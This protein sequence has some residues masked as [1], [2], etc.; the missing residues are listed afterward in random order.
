MEKIL[1]RYGNAD[2]T[3][4]E[5]SKEVGLSWHTLYKH[6]YRDKGMR[7]FTSF[8][9]KRVLL[10][11]KGKSYTVPELAKK[12]DVAESTLYKCHTDGFTDLTGY[13]KH[14]RVLV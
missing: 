4:R 3:L 9:P 1:V 2:I 7:D 13:K 10:N 14:K 11:Y 12:L 6:Y 8:K 5:L